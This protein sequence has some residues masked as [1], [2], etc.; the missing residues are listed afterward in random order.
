MGFS[1]TPLTSGNSGLSVS[2]TNVVLGK[3]DESDTGATGC[4]GISEIMGKSTD[5]N[6]VETGGSVVIGWLSTFSPALSLTGTVGVA[7]SIEAV[8]IGVPSDLHVASF[9]CL[10]PSEYARTYIFC[11]FGHQRVTVPFHLP[12]V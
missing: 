3:T 9:P 10:T 6:S 4:E 1:T 5:G 11:P 12:S 2:G 7:L 8:L